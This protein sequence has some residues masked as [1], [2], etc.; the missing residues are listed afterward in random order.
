MALHMSQ[1]R[2]HVFASYMLRSGQSLALDAARYEGPPC[3]QSKSVCTYRSCMYDLVGR[4]PPESSGTYCIRP[5]SNVHCARH[6][7]K[8]SLV[9]ACFHTGRCAVGYS[10]RDQA[11]CTKMYQKGSG[12]QNVGDGY[13]MSRHGWAEA[14]L[15]SSCADYLVQGYASS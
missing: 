13:M 14:S 1:A 11:A 3:A 15:S 8:S 9:T 7:S 12:C 10:W 5:L 6:R 2:P 4:R